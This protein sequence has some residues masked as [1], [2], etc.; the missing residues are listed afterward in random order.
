MAA[1]KVKTAILI[2]G[3]GSNMVALVEAAQLETF[4]AE[5]VGVISNRPGAAGLEKAQALKVPTAVVDHK[6]YKT[7]EA[8]EHALHEQLLSMEAE[9][10]CCAGFMRILTPWFV[11]NWQDRL[12]NIHPS[13]LPKY[14]GLNTHQRA[15]DAGDSETGCSVHWVTEDLDAGAVILQD[16]VTI[17]PND[18][19]DLLAA[20]L[21]PIE[22][23]LYP[24]A[25]SKV[26]KQ[27]QSRV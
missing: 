10:V 22:L 27:I 14:K 8:F 12:I 5:I 25:L 3:R 26:A 21:L 1:Q 11:S 2:S 17:S 20:R 6:N 4:P 23:S 15:I 9:L 19:A 13:L 16:S 24:K 18:T 7:R